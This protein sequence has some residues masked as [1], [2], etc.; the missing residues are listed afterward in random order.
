MVNE[1]LLNESKILS[2]YIYKNGQ[3]KKPIGYESVGYWQ[4][5]NNG[6]YSEAFYKNGKIF[7]VYRGT[8]P[9][10]EHFGE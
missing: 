6:F 9:P 5:K 1:A 10:L 3:C 8:E 4:N 7:I 2:W